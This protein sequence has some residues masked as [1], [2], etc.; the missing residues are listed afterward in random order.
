MGK[1]GRPPHPDI[2]T[3]REREVLALIRDG[4]SNDDIG[5]RLGIS[6]DG[7]KYHV[8]QIL[9]KLGVSSRQEAADWNEE[10]PPW[11]QRALAPFAWAWRKSLS[12]TAQQ[13]WVWTA[14]FAVLLLIAISAF[15]LLG[16]LLW[17]SHNNSNASETSAS[18]ATATALRTSAI[19]TPPTGAPTPGVTWTDYTEPATTE[20]GAPLV[21][22]SG[23]YCPPGAAS[24]NDCRG[25]L[26]D[27]TDGNSWKLLYQGDQALSA[28]QFSD[29]QNGWAAVQ[30]ANVL[31]NSAPSCPSML[32][33]TRDGGASWRAIYTAPDT[34]GLAAFVG[35]AADV[36]M[37]LAPRDSC[38]PGSCSYSF[39]RTADH[40]QTWKES[41]LP[42]ALSAEGV[43]LF[44]ANASDGWIVSGAQVVATHDGG[45]TWVPLARPFPLMNNDLDIGSSVFFFS[46]SRGWL[47][48]G[49]QP[50]AGNQAKELFSTTDGGQTWAHLSG[51]LFD[52]GA[53]PGQD[54]GNLGTSG[55]V[56]QMEFTSESQG[57]TFLSRAGLL[58]SDDGGINWKPVIQAAGFHGFHFVDAM[59]GWLWT[60][61]PSRLLM[62]SD[63]GTTWLEFHFP[64]ACI[65][66]DRS[67][68]PPGVPYCY[69][70]P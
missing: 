39:F 33:A 32:Y 8:S 31:C 60:D 7:V 49:G 23:E 25:I 47:L 61:F 51:S 21:Y 56:G 15:T 57:W 46:A 45:Q 13:T 22:L 1:R 19:S 68:P 55:Y 18:I 64:P 53:T 20:P 36:W 14:L 65:N 11:W 24:T 29:I 3:P 37:L 27:S 63:G 12:F 28:I 30:P 6:V 26:E 42:N 69:P 4:L 16:V 9:S 62:T 38:R 44:R 34:E 70:N 5:A 66:V 10:L 40:G 41:A 35:T 59:H 43:T 54:N 58:R 17:R 2:L 48:V 50:S 52:P 67:P